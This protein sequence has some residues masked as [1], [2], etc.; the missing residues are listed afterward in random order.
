MSHDDELGRELSTWFAQ[1]A[2]PGVPAY[3]EELIGA[4]RSAGQ[5][6]RWAMLRGRLPSGSGAAVGGT[7]GVVP[8]RTIGLVALLVLALAAMFGVWVAS[9]RRVLPPPYGPVRNGLLAYSDGD[10]HVVDPDTGRR[11]TIVT[12]PTIY[13][14]GGLHWGELNEQPS[15]AV[16]PIAVLGP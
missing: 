15:P 12:G 16:T 8:W 4:T 6:R 2:M 11:A 1:T 13:C 10:I 14:W 3:V 9:E 5:R 7:L